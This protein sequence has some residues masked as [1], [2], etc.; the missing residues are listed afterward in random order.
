M[1][2]DDHN[3][4]TSRPP[5]AEAGVVKITTLSELIALIDAS[6]S[7]PVSK[8]RY[9]RSA[10]NRTKVLLGHGLADV[11]ADPKEILRRLD[12]LS[13][14]MADMT[15]QSYANLKSRVRSALRHAAPHLAPARSRISLSSE[16]AA[17]CAAAPTRERCQLSR[18]FRYAHSMGWLPGDIGEAQ[19]EQ[20]EA[21]LEHEAMR[22]DFAKVVRTTRRAWN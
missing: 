22:S 8:K 9:L 14:A 15:P 21:H 13:P 7:I 17:L 19:I 6:D 12:G 5:V 16:W 2:T 3:N 20:F 18:L 4:A 10:V 11:K 1:N